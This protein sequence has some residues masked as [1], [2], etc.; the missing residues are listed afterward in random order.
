MAWEL[1]DDL[2]GGSSTSIRE[3]GAAATP[4]RA[5]ATGGVLG[6][7]FLGPATDAAN[8][9]DE[10][11]SAWVAIA[12]MPDARFAHGC[13]AISTKVYVA[14]GKD[15]SGTIR[16]SLFE[17]NESTGFWSTKAAMPSAR[18][19]NTL[20]KVGTKLY[21]IGGHDGSSPLNT[22]SIWNQGTNAWSAGANMPAALYLVG[23]VAVGTDIFVFG[24]FDG[25]SYVDSVFKYDTL[26]DTWSTLGT[27][28]EVMAPYS[29][30]VALL[31]GIVYV[32]YGGIDDPVGGN[33]DKTTLRSYDPSTDTWAIVDDP[34]PLYVDITAVCATSSYLY[35]IAGRSSAT[36]NWLYRWH[37]TKT[38][39]A[40]L[41]GLT[42]TA[43]AF[44]TASGIA[45]AALGGLAGTATAGVSLQ[46]AGAAGLGSLQGAADGSV[47]APAVLGTGTAALG[48]LVGAARAV[49]TPPDQPRYALPHRR[50]RSHRF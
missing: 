19:G 44:S 30:T 43:T 29:N 28:P 41:G 5:Y 11:T 24:G 9:Y 13:A 8:Y 23:A 16:S 10:L 7:V 27:A 46:G 18:F 15:G 37:Q 42:G 48:E 21:S 50:V 4:G 20:V 34:M 31:D 45:N 32:L 39:T 3:H 25:T 14:G 2:P 26:T 36:G 1:L 35:A 12:N 33:L 47:V 40:D 22:L 38:G 6:N 17:F 49:Q